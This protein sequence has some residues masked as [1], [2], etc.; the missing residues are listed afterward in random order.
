MISPM[1]IRETH[2][3]KLADAKLGW[4]QTSYPVLGIVGG[5]IRRH[6]DLGFAKQR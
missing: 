2:A 1:K 3:D 4:T 6:T 5:C